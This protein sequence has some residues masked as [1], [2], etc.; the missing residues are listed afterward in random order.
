MSDKEHRNAPNGKQRT[1]NRRGILLGGSTMAAAAI[2]F[3]ASTPGTVTGST[4]AA[5]AVRTQTRTF[6]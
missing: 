2:A 6:W 4:G 1:L 3:G 5:G